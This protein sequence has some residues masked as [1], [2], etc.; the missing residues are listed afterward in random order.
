MANKIKNRGNNKTKE[1]SAIQLVADSKKNKPTQLKIKKP[2]AKKKTV[3]QIRKAVQ[4][5]KAPRSRRFTVVS[6]TPD[7]ERDV[8]VRIITNSPKENLEVEDLT[9]GLL[10]KENLDYTATNKAGLNISLDEYV[11][12]RESSKHVTPADMAPC[13]TVGKTVKMVKTKLNES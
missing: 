10:L 4:K 12:N 6:A 3:T 2:A 8:K 7:T 1:K 5:K 11:N 9:D 13:D